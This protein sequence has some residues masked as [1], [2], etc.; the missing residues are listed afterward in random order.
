MNIKYFLSLERELLAIHKDFEKRANKEY[1]YENTYN[2]GLI[3]QAF[4]TRRINTE[5]QFNPRRNLQNY[6]RS[7]QF[8]TKDLSNQIKSFFK[9]KIAADLI[10]EQFLGDPD[11]LDSNTRIL[12][13]A[14]DNALRIEQQDFD[15]F[16][17]QF[18]YLNEL[19]Y[20]RYRLASEDIDKLEENKIKDILLAKDERLMYKSI[21]ANYKPKTIEKNTSINHNG[22]T[23]TDKLFAGVK[24]NS[25]NKNVERSINITIKDSILDDKDSKKE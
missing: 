5:T 24:A 25:E 16:K 7:E 2:D 18:D 23:L 17:P 22:D 13:N 15:F 1:K 12:C 8:I 21:Y 4:D 19:L 20:L 9:I 11:W 6:S 3:K 14:V 10:K